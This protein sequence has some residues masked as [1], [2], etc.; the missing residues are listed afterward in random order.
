MEINESSPLKY[1]KAPPIRSGNDVRPTEGDLDSRAVIDK[2]NDT[3]AT[4]SFKP[5]EERQKQ[6]ANSLGTKEDE[7]LSGQFVIQYEVEREN[8]GGEVRN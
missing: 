7:G 5:N 2:V 1:V 3:Y 4:I 6:L 8:N